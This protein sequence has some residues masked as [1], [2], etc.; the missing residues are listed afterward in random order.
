MPALRLMKANAV[1][2][3]ASLLAC[4][5][6]SG[7]DAEDEGA[8][9]GDFEMHYRAGGELLIDLQIDASLSFS[10][11]MPAVPQLDDVRVAQT[12]A[13]V[14]GNGQQ[15]IVLEVSST[16]D[17]Q[18][19]D[20]FSAR[21]EFSRANDGDIIDGGGELNMSCIFAWN[22]ADGGFFSLSGDCD[23]RR[24]GDGYTLEVANVF[25]E[26]TVLSG[27]LSFSPVP[28]EPYAY[29]PDGGCGD[30]LI[31]LSL[32]PQ[33]YD[34]QTG[35]CLPTTNLK[36]QAPSCNG[37]CGEQLNISVGGSEVC[38]CSWACGRLDSS[39][40]GDPPVCDPA[41]GCIDF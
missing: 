8:G 29:T 11:G 41:Y 3:L 27:T 16:D 36:S 1:A 18:V 5:G 33:E 22:L 15:V 13:T 26:Q 7:G 2:T 4:A 30:G 31:C 35:Y 38:V 12:H 24:D 21:L 28:N 6:G 20:R 40:G 14:M 39:G 10:G 34:P 25:F 37:E 19:G 17:L 23:V 9:G 32:D